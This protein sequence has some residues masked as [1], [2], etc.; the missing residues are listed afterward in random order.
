MFR[1][2]GAASILLAMACAS[3]VLAAG[4]SDKTD[5]SGLN[6]PETFFIADPDGAI[7]DCTRVIQG[8][9]T[10]RE[11]AIASIDRAIAYL[12]RANFGKSDNVAA[13]RDAAAADFDEAVRLDPN[14]AFAH[15][16]R[17]AGAFFSLRRGEVADFDE[18]I[19]LDPTFALA[20]L[21]RAKAWYFKGDYKRAEA[22]Y[23]AAIRLDA[24]LGRAYLGRG[25]ERRMTGDDD[26]AI[27]DLSEALRLSTNDR[28]TYVRIADAR[29]AMFFVRG[30]HDRAVADFSD[31]LRLDPQDAYAL[32]QR[33]VV[34]LMRG[35]LDL[36]RADLQQATDLAPTNAEAAL[37]REIADRRAHVKGRLAEAA[38][39]L[40][41]R[42]WPASVV[43][44]FLGEPSSLTMLEE[45]AADDVGSPIIRQLQTCQ[46]YV[47]TGEL[48]LLKVA[49]A[50][51]AEAF[52]SAA[53]ACPQGAPERGVVAAELKSLRATP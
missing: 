26:G 10:P 20:Y 29:G 30:E 51:A 33:G 28:N 45:A 40:N 52:T 48:A 5:C 50:E 37:W 47:F 3:A 7:K 27:A 12:E 19:R 34:Q 43:D 15:Y 17:G 41:M 38:E 39:K 42:H 6:D 13:D 53:R 49:K 14:F 22:D 23:S 46:A 4:Q 24:M 11:R 31:A 36:A 16:A 32:Q 8:V 35:S 2:L 18:A 44:S 9:G 1:H 21:G 25:A